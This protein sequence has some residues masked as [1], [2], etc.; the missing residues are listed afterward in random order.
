MTI[1]FPA[2]LMRL[3]RLA[4]AG[5]IGALLCVHAAGAGA[6]RDFELHGMKLGAPLN[7]ALNDS[8][9]DCDGASGCFLYTVCALKSIYAEKFAGVPLQGERLHFNG[10]RLA[11]IEATFPAAQFDAVLQALIAAYGSGAQ[12]GS[13][14][15]AAP[16][17]DVRVWRHGRQLL[18]LERFYRSGDRSSLILTED[19]LLSELIGEK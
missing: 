14:S 3:P 11:A 18:R 12:G 1:S 13:D 17:D 9:L 6:D 19:N 15:A 10:E 8:R 2:F 5:L 7:D 16:G 4:G